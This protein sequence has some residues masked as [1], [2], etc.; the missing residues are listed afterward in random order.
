MV[1]R[2]EA[3]FEAGLEKEGNNGG[4]RVKG[5]GGTVLQ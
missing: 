3:D 2:F 1:F 5:A 4:Y